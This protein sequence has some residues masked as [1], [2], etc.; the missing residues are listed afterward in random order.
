[1][2]LKNYDYQ[3][4]IIQTLKDGGYYK[5]DL[6]EIKRIAWENQD[7]I[8]D[9]KNEPYCNTIIRYPYEF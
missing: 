5:G 8:E 1:M 9:S 3:K 7:I 6:Q 4:S 2:L